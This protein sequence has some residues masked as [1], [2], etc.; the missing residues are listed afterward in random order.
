MRCSLKGIDVRQLVIPAIFQT[1]FPDQ[2][3][4]KSAEQ[5]L[6]YI[7]DAVGTIIEHDFS[8]EAIRLEDV[9]D[10]IGDASPRAI[11]KAINKAQKIA[12]DAYDG[13][14]NPPTSIAPEALIY[15]ITAHTIYE[16]GRLSKDLIEYTVRTYFDSMFDV[17]ALETESDMACWAFL[18]DYFEDNLRYGGYRP[19]SAILKRSGHKFVSKTRLNTFIR[20]N[21][22][23]GV[24]EDVADVFQI[25][26]DEPGVVDIAMAGTKILEAYLFKVA[27]DNF[28]TSKAVVNS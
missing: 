28:E 9:A 26:M 13:E 7:E 22:W 11:K 8:A 19:I 24:E 12:H 15:Q 27:E 17:S 1:P 25:W 14:Y 23:W 6:E 3:A 4:I 16:C 18:I 21:C 5:G 10:L 20:K 2:Q